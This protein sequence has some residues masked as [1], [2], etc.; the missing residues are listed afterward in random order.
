[1]KDTFHKLAT[2]A[3]KLVGT[4]YAFIAA[5][6][7]IAGWLLSGPAFGYS[8]T[9]QLVINTTTTIVTFLMV[10]LI[11]HT[12]NRD[13]LAL[14]L[15]L[16]ELIRATGDARNSMIDLDQLSDAQL[17]ELEHEFRRIC[18]QGDPSERRSRRPRTQGTRGSAPE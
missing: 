3:S 10:L 2:G 12:Q 5:L 8:D 4:A 1:M 16:D 6:A 11:Q 15:K 17:L 9:W 13:A 14:H 18:A 7:L